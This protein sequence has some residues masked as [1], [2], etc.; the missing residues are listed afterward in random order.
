MPSS[1]TKRRQAKIRQAKHDAVT[2]LKQ[3]ESDRIEQLQRDADYSSR[4]VKNVA[5]SSDM[6]VFGQYA[7][8][9][10][11]FIE[12]RVV[13]DKM[14]ELDALMQLVDGIPTILFGSS[15]Y[16]CFRNRKD[17]YDN[18]R[19]VSSQVQTDICIAVTTFPLEIQQTILEYCG[20]VRVSNFLPPNVNRKLHYFWM[21][22]SEFGQSRDDY[23]TILEKYLQIEPKN[24]SKTDWDVM[25]CY[26]VTLTTSSDRQTFRL[27]ILQQFRDRGVGRV[28]Y[29]ENKYHRGITGQQLRVYTGQLN[30]RH[31]DIVFGYER[32][33]NDMKTKSDLCST[34]CFDLRST[35]S[36]SVAR[37]FC[38]SGSDP[39]IVVLMHIF[40]MNFM[41]D[42]WRNGNRSRTTTDRRIAKISERWNCPMNGRYPSYFTAVQLLEK[43]TDLFKTPQLMEEITKHILPETRVGFVPI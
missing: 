40:G 23:R 35:E 2:A 3:D 22:P 14:Y 9:I 16:N 28:T 15:V 8:Q 6:S 36:E 31:I 18:V 43:G 10:T 25:I 24:I 42:E 26:P 20:M 11:E 13:I 39:I 37:F 5:R 34:M 27:G 1:A 30:A 33:F 38:A 4:L 21:H 32:V 17:G 19:T 12:R 41:C 7:D 29:M